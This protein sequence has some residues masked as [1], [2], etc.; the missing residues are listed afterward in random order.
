MNILEDTTLINND[1]LNKINIDS[2]FE[3]KLKIDNSINFDYSLTVN[4]NNLINLNEYYVIG[5][6][7]SKDDYNVSEI[8]NGVIISINNTNYFITTYVPNAKLSEN[9]SITYGP[10]NQQLEISNIINQYMFNLTAFEIK[11]FKENPIIFKY[12]PNIITTNIISNRKSD[13]A[14]ILL[15]NNLNDSIELP[16]NLFSYD[17][18]KN[19]HPKL[20][21]LLIIKISLKNDIDIDINISD[22]YPGNAVIRKYQNKNRLLGIISNIELTEDGCNIILIPSYT[23]LS[24]LRFI[25]SNKLTNLW[26]DINNNIITNIYKNSLPFLINKNNIEI[27]DQLLTIDDKVIMNGCIFDEITNILIPIHTYVWYNQYFSKGNIKNTSMTEK[28]SYSLLIKKKDQS[29]VT[30]NY[31]YINVDNILTI[32]F[33]H[34]PE[35]FN[36]LDRSFIFQYISFELIDYL[37]DKSIFLEGDL[38]NKLFDI[39]FDE[40]YNNI[41]ISKFDPKNLR[42]IYSNIYDLINK[43]N[44]TEALCGIVSTKIIFLDKVCNDEIK[45]L[46]DI[47]KYFYKN[48]NISRLIK[49][50]GI[51]VKE[52]KPITAKINNDLINFEVII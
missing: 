23:I 1:N 27:G 46:S 20:P 6:K 10:A 21:N 39:P 24:F 37:L 32:G 19:K 33:N 18:I 11:N 7:M 28:E 44:D 16:L 2:M 17:F 12:S 5:S 30:V 42:I 36:L 9:F 22:I 25:K 31:P 14:Y 15:E 52:S 35:A 29:I 38:I 34:I 43:T 45:S 4:I 3:N 13:S 49:S 26:F 40:K 48:E 41:I 47:A 50:Y 8:I 51:I